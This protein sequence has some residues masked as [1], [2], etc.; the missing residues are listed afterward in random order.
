[1]KQFSRLVFLTATLC[2]AHT[3]TAGHDLD[4]VQN[5]KQWPEQVQYRAGL[6][7]GAVFFTH[8]RFVYSYYSS[9]DLKRIHKLTEQKKDNRHE[10]I[11]GHAYQVIFAGCN[12]DALAVGQDRQPYYHN[13]FLGGDSLKWSA[14]VPVFRS[15]RYEELYPGIGLWVYSSGPSMKYDF[16]AAPGADPASIRLQFDGVTPRL[17]A[18]GT[19]EIKTSVNTVIEQAPYVYQMTGGRKKEIKCRY[20]LNRK[21]EVG[22]D[23]PEGYDRSRELIIDPTLVFATW[24]GCA[25]EAFGGN[26]TYDQAGNVYCNASVLG[27]GWPV[28]SGAFQTTPGVMGS[29]AINKYNSTGTA[30][31]YSTY[32]GGSNGAGALHL[33]TNGSDELVVFGTTSSPDFPVTTGCY[34]N[35]FNGSISDFFITH[36]NAGGTALIGSTF[37]GGGSNE[38]GPGR[39]DI[40]AAGNIICAG[41]TIS[42]DFP[43]TPGAY[44]PAATS[45][46]NICVFKL[47]ATCTSLLA[48]SFLGGS[49]ADYP[50]DLKVSG[51]GHIVVCGITGST[52]F[53]ATAGTLNPVFQGGVRDGFVS[54]L[55]S[56]A[57]ALLYSTFL[58]TNQVDQAAGLQLDDSG[59]VYVIGITR[60]NYPVT[61]GVY[62]NPNGGIFIHVLEPSLTGIMSTRLTTLADSVSEICA[63]YVDGCRRIAFAVYSI[64]GVLPLTSNAY[65]ASGGLYLMQLDAGLASLNYATYLTAGHSHGNA[66]FDP[67][68]NLYV[69]LCEDD[70]FGSYPTT[71]GVWSP[72]SLFPGFDARTLRFQLDPF[73]ADAGFEID[74]DDTGCA[75]FTVTFTNN[76]GGSSSCFWDF[77]DGT[78]STAASPTHTYMPPGTYQVMLAVEDTGSCKPRDTAY[79]TITV[80]QNTVIA[81]GSVTNDTGC[82]PLLVQTVNSSTGAT[83]YEWDFGDGSALVPG[84]TPTHLYALPGIYRVVLHAFNFGV[85]SNSRTDTFYVKVLEP[86]PVAAIDLEVN[87]SGCAPYLAVLDNVST[88]A[89][90]YL[91]SFG[92]GTTSSS[93]FPGSHLYGNPG[94]YEVILYAYNYDS[95]VCKSADTD[96][97]MIHVYPPADVEMTVSDTSVCEGNGIVFGAQLSNNYATAAWDF[98]DGSQVSGPAMLA[99][100]YDSS[101]RYRVTLTVDHFICP[102]SSADTFVT[103]VPVPATVLGPD[104]SICL[105]GEPVLLANAVY[106]AANRHLWN[107]NDTTRSILVRH[108]GTYWLRTT[109]TE[110]CSS[111]DSVAVL[112]SCYI[113]IPNAFT[114][115]GDGINDFFFPRVLLSEKLTGFRM[116]VFNRWGQVVFETNRIDG[117][118]WDGKFNDVDQPQ[119]VYIYLIDAEIDRRISEQYRGNVT[120]LR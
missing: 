86:G 9:G 25:G 104:T 54:V 52:D 84:A 66:A 109:N 113:D 7:G 77:G 51:N 87:D 115:N 34:D 92:D 8:D 93:Q 44:Q 59:N 36:F 79:A 55:N 80:V 88:G 2:A 96:R 73:A 102:D 49:G 13:Y 62:T 95:L 4:F 37:I 116:Q 70:Q 99:H 47:D 46:T 35:T 112:K 64:A 19:L 98:G 42:S 91:W 39:M 89:T 83:S 32:L 72:V 23:F 119:G 30:L 15:I 108:H 40:D 71:P 56:G 94:S 50:G 45:D 110:G 26:A 97:M 20:V 120:L 111:T 105:Y 18:E 10:P 53:P 85:C 41:T 68:G 78:T 60:G 57:T 117:R 63:F 14:H 24:S 101:G 43:V 22:F 33:A 12:K 61:P 58:G 27:P 103:I 82:A 16:I 5:D 21:G 75:P 90:S 107:T 76:T 67:P 1:M 28:T 106:N 48:S 114:P 38:V 3:A 81:N 31:I 69:T 11:R 100:A 74:G 17:T 118:G 29:I 65:Q 6:P